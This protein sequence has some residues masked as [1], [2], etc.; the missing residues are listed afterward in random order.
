MSV[1]RSISGTANFPLVPRP[2]KGFAPFCSLYMGSTDGAV[3]DPSQEHLI[4]LTLV[5]GQVDD[6]I[7]QCLKGV[8]IQWRFC[9]VF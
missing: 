2:V 1:L 4:S 6:T 3:P 5:K 9:T 7:L 8:F